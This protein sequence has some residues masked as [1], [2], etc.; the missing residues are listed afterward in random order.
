MATGCAETKANVHKK[1]E[2]TDFA[3]KKNINIV[4]QQKEEDCE[5]SHFSYK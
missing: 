5:W 2:K 3:S 1:K 4:T